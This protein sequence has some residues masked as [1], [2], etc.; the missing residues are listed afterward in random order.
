MRRAAALSL[1]ILFSI[2]TIVPLTLSS[3]QEGVDRPTVTRRTK[4]LKRYSRA[5]WRRYRARIQR[6]RA[7][8]ARQRAINNWRKESVVTLR[9]EEPRSIRSNER[10]SQ[11][12][13]ARAA[14]GGIYN[15]PRG[16]FTMTLP[17]GWSNRP[18]IAGGEMRFRVFQRDGSPIGQA[19]L[20]FVS[21][22]GA[23]V[24]EALPVRTRR[25]MLA[26]VPVADLRRIAIDKMLGAN[27]WVT[28][29][30]QRE[31]GG[32]RVFVVLAQTAASTDGRTPA[33]S[34]AFYFMEVEG[35]IYNLTASAAPEHSERLT[36]ETEK[37]IS[38]FRSLGR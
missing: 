28:N 37:A 30:F 10:S 23:P 3:A 38:S 35:R 31:V 16:Q 5:W 21:E 18:V 8:L 9:S 12:S 24:S 25:N 13:N 29:D 17:N 2:V 34:W 6:R 19:A 33:Q 20:A 32:R 22:A 15:D 27:G 4:R 7:A 26:G 11:R 36:A 1:L 14:T